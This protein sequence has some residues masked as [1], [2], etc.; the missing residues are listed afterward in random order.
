MSNSTPSNLVLRCYG[1]LTS[2]GKYYGVCLEL[3]LAAEADSEMELKEKLSS[4]ISSYIE[5]VTDTE[6]KDSIP[7]LLDRPAP[8]LDHLKY[9][10]IRLLLYYRKRQRAPSPHSKRY[11]L[12]KLAGNSFGFAGNS[13]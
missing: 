6:D 8:L 13:A 5:T 7:D 3:N 1:H 2:A 11:S 12:F 4:I 9:H 10:S